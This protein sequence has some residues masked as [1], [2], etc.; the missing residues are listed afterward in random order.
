M[1]DTIELSGHGRPLERPPRRFPPQNRSG[2]P[3]ALGEVLSKFA[4]RAGNLAQNGIG[5]PTF[6]PENENP[7]ER[8]RALA[9]ASPV[10]TAHRGDSGRLPENT[11]PAFAAATAL[12]CAMQEF[13]VR[14]TRDGELVCIHDATPDRTTN[15]AQLLGPDRPIVATDLAT[16]RTLDAGGGAVVPRLDEAL[17]AIRPGIPMIE[18]K[19]GDPAT[20]LT[21]LRQR[22]ELARCILQSFDWGFVAAVKTAAPEAA[23]ALLGPGPFAARLD[24]EA[25]AA[26]RRLGAGMLH[27]RDR[28]LDAATVARVHA[29]GLLVCSYTTDDADGMRR[30]ARIGIDA[31]CT[32][33]PGRMLELARAGELH[34]AR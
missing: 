8:L 1:G 9:A 7:F 30:G 4:R 24:A 20:F 31:M 13:D 6:M 19:A 11:L 27:W 3:K 33:E 15:A 2:A 21:L 29:A 17:A 22:G 5:Q 32:N 18:H 26:A 10:V 25:I 23:V 34:R 28:D 16:L 14:E 12:G